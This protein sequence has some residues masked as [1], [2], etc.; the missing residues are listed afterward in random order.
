[1]MLE[2]EPLAIPEV[3]LIKLKKHE[4]SRGFF[5]KLIASRRFRRPVSILPSYRTTI[6]CHV[7]R[8]RCADYIIRFSRLPRAS[9][10]ASSVGEFLMWPSIYVANPPPL[11]DGWRSNCRRRHGT[12]S[13]FPLGS[14]TA[15]A[16]LS[17]IPR[18]SIRLRTFIRRSTNLVSDGTT[19]N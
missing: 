4:D 9:W 2:M 1:M 10:F 19:R 5:L 14:P 8:G 3:K 11:G 15:S 6:H 12:R 13:S 17:R 7:R 18:L 16:P